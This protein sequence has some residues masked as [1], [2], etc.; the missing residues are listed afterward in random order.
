MNL[1]Q[2][3]QLLRSINRQQKRHRPTNLMSL[4][5]VN[6]VAPH[7]H[8]INGEIFFQYDS[9]E[10]DVDES[11]RFLMFYTISGLRR[12]CASRIIL[13]DGTF[14]TI[15]NIFYQLCSIHGG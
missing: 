15:P 5:D 12:L 8:T 3:T 4:A 13:Y 10:S 6:I 2:R 9:L 7:T 1:P 11:E 14:K